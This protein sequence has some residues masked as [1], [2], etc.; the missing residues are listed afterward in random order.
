MEERARARRRAAHVRRAQSWTIVPICTTSKSLPWHGLERVQ[1]A[2]VPALVGRARH[3]PVPAVVGEEHAVLLEAVE[4]DA[5]LRRERARVEGRL[6]PHAHP[7]GRAVGAAVARGPV[8]RRSD[9]RAA[10]LHGR[11]AQRMADRAAA[12]D[13]VVADEPREHGEARRV[14]RREALRGGPATA[15][16]RRTR[17]CP[18]STR[19]SRGTSSGTC[20]TSRRGSTRR[21]RPRAR[22]GRRRSARR[23]R[24]GR[25]PGSGRGP[26]RSRRR[27]RT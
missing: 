6:E 9:V 27:S 7:H 24:S 18:P 5:R 12:D 13:L 1:L 17:R 14:R 23:P 15:R 21:G 16:G 2:V 19:S 3:E 22:G 10:G 26:R 8:R 20:S 11:E 25:R 4:D